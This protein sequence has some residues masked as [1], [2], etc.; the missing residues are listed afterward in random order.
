M[1]VEGDLSNENWWKH[2]WRSKIHERTKFFLWNQS[3]PVLNNLAARRMSL[4]NLECGHGCQSSE[5][6]IHLFFH[7]EIAKIL[8]FASPWGIQWE[9]FGH[10]DILAFL[11]FLSNLEGYLPVHQEDKENF[12]M[13]IAI[14]LEH[15]WWI[16]NQIVHEGCVE[17]I[18]TTPAVVM[19]R[20][21]ELKEAISRDEPVHFPRTSNF[22]GLSHVWRRPPEGVIKFNTDAAVRNKG[23]HLE[24][25]ARNSKGKVLHIQAFNSVVNVPQTAELD[26]ILKAMQVAKNFNCNSIQFELNA[27]NM[28]RAL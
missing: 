16:R 27:L 7:C 10:N 4:E 11:K 1:D 24:V 9:E 15:I 5:I 3:L 20:F 2:L 14:T 21:Q 25:V 26:A 6:E 8:W 19:K 28:I 23:S 13:Y 18:E 17:N 12:F 22:A